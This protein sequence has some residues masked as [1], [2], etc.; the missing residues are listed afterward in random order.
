MEKPS[1][2]LHS[3][4]LFT[5]RTRFAVLLLLIFL[6]ATRGWAQNFTFTEGRLVADTYASPGMSAINGSKPNL[7]IQ[8][9]DQENTYLLFSLSEA[10]GAFNGVNVQGATLRLFVNTV[11][12]PGTMYVCL[13]HPTP[14]WTDSSVTGLPG[15][16]P[17]CDISVSPIAVPISA[18]QVDQ[19]VDV[20]VTPIV[21][22]WLSGAKTNNGIGVMSFNPANLSQFDGVNVQLDAK[23]NT[24]TSHPAALQMSLLAT[25]SVPGLVTAPTCGANQFFNGVSAS[26]TLQC[27]P[28]S[29]GGTVTDVSTGPGILGGP[30]TST[31]TLSL[32]TTFTDARYLKPNG[33]GSALTN[34]NAFTL[35]GLPPGAFAQVGTSATPVTQTLNGTV[36]LNGNLALS[37]LNGTN[38]VFSVTDADGSAFKVTSSAFFDNGAGGEGHISASA[39]IPGG[40]P[41]GSLN[42][43]AGF[44]GENGSDLNLNSGSAG[45]PDATAG[46]VN[47]NAGRGGGNINLNPGSGTPPG[48]VNVFGDLQIKE[49]GFISFADGTTLSTGGVGALGTATSPVNNTYYGNQDFQGNVTLTSGGTLTAPSV[50]TGSV[51]ANSVSTGTLTAS[52][53][54]SGASITAPTFV[55]N[56]NGTASNAIDLGGAPASNYLQTNQNNTISANDTFTGIE[57]FTGGVEFSGADVA[58]DFKLPSTF[59]P[60]TGGAITFNGSGAGNTN[61]L[62][63]GNAPATTTVAGNSALVN[64]DTSGINSG[65][66]L[67]VNTTFQFQAQTQGNNT[68]NPIPSFVLSALSGSNPA[69]SIFTI[70][71]TGNATIPTVNT[72]KFCLAGVCTTSLPTGGGTIAGVIAGTDLTGGGTSGLITL[73]L[74]T[75]RVATLAGTNAFTSTG[76]QTFSGPVSAAALQTSGAVTGGAGNFNLLGVTGNGSFGAVTTPQVLGNSNGVFLCGDA[77]SCGSSITSGAVHVTPAGAGGAVNIFGNLSESG[78]MNVTSSTTGSPALKINQQSSSD[79]LAEF[80]GNGHPDLIVRDTSGEVVADLSGVGGAGFFASCSGGGLS[81]TNPDCHQGAGGG[82]FSGGTTS[83]P[84]PYFAFGGVNGANGSRGVNVRIAAGNGGLSTA[85][86]GNGGDFELESGAGGSGGTGGLPGNVFINA[87]S[88]GGIFLGPPPATPPSAQSLVVDMPGVFNNGVTLSNL[89]PGCAVI[90]TS[91]SLSSGPCGIS[92]LTAGTGI[93]VSGS[94]ISVNPAVIPELT[95]SGALNIGGNITVGTGSSPITLNAA[96][97]GIIAGNLNINNLTA[98]GLISAASIAT[99]GSINVGSSLSV[100]TITDG[101]TGQITLTAGSNVNVNS[102]LNVNGTGSAGGSIGIASGGVTVGTLT[103]AGSNVS[104]TSATGNVVLSNAPGSSSGTSLTLSNA[105]GGMISVQAPGSIT[106]QTN[107]IISATGDFNMAASPATTSQNANPSPQ[108]SVTSS[109]FNPTT[110]T[111]QAFSFGFQ[112]VP[113]AGASSPTA[114]FALLATNTLGSLA[115]T[116]TSFD[117]F[118]RLHAPAVVDSATGHV[119]SLPPTCANNGATAV[120][121]SSNTT[122]PWGCGSASGGGLSGLSVTAPITTTG[123]QT[124]TLGLSVVPVSLGGTGSTAT[125]GTNQFLVGNSSGGYSPRTLLTTDLPTCA[126]NNLFVYTLTGP[127][128][129]AAGSFPIL[130]AGLLGPTEF[131]LGGSFTLDVNCTNVPCKGNSFSALNGPLLIGN[132]LSINGTASGNASIGVA[133]TAGTPNTILLPTSTGPAGSVLTTDGNSPQQTSW[134]DSKTL[135]GALP[136]YNVSGTLQPSAHAVTASG[137]IGTAGTTTITLSGAAAFTSVSSY[138]CTANDS[139]SASV[140]RVSNASG[141]SLTLFGSAGDTYYVICTGN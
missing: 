95:T 55:G 9:T 119:T 19:F 15:N 72:S 123:G 133:A 105:S 139:T 38:P 87:A 20:N 32:D 89:P 115:P 21:Q 13:L 60:G 65:T 80:D 96:N 88:G 48:V 51:T 44:T 64:L 77:N 56:L 116:Q 57:L 91:S 46:N 84:I 127:A 7:K 69:A 97:G 12:S 94:M 42:V 99:P 53:P 109:I 82:F 23:E 90:T 47:I 103:A 6:S 118:G 128:C 50:S 132:R 108:L 73:N 66:G 125:P 102:N 33:S 76:T 3:L 2:A 39:P 120:Y 138:G 101:G 10:G 104:L 49:G 62:D 14:T 107:D 54:I 71:N 4:V 117:G 68:P 52:G 70:D 86:G 141:N 130:G 129:T 45:N 106:L 26:G 31:G 30:I 100:P 140:I 41:G 1:H 35:G 78:A 136:V 110:N 135:A 93:Q 98:S 16:T 5:H 37:P 43:S 113:L 85:T 27:A 121:N 122:N 11:T 134:A 112:T 24:N 25:S 124:P 81:S 111:A 29:A 8:G 58:A 34:V 137:T 79:L 18:S 28:G 75:T 114:N 17:A 40:P 36:N 83:N 63:L 59:R 67:P 61:T 92:S 22:E 131:P 74:D 126:A